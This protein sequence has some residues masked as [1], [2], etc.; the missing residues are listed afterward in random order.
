MALRLTRSAAAFNRRIEKV[1]AR[2]SG[3]PFRPMPK[4]A[5]SAISWQDN[6]PPGTIAFAAELRAGRPSEATITR[7]V[8]AVQAAG[9]P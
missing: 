3:L 5:R 6:A 1:F 7:P 9:T 2:A 8:R 4:L